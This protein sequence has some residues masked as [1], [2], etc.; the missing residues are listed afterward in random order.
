MVILVDKS[1]EKCVIK[2]TSRTPKKKRDK[3]AIVTFPGNV[4]SINELKDAR[5]VNFQLVVYVFN[6]SR[7]L[8]DCRGK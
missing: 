8:E 4:T 7:L 1:T 5:P 2:N 3:S 6:K